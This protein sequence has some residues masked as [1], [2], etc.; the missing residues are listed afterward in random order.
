[1]GEIEAKILKNQYISEEILRSS[2]KYESILTSQAISTSHL[3]LEHL[4]NMI[5]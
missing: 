4:L 3:N 2:Q 1:V 5:I